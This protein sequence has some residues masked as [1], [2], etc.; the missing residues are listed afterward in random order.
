MRTF[1]HGDNGV[2]TYEPN[3]SEGEIEVI[4]C[5]DTDYTMDY[6]RGPVPLSH[7]LKLKQQDE[8]S[9]W[10]T[11][12]NQTLRREAGIPGTREINRLAGLEPTNWI[13]RPDRMRKLA[14]LF[15]GA[16][17]MFVVDDCNLELLEPVWDYYPPGVYAEQILGID[18]ACVMEPRFEF[19]R[20]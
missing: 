19:E 11:G 14:R 17:E 13:P 10:A 4:A 7:I 2:Q 20:V 6:A 9:V 18:D 12:H 1:V 8:V 3:H 5:F 16:Q 15:P